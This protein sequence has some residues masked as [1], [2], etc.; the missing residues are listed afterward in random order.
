M[1]LWFSRPCDT[2]GK[3]IGLIF[4]LNLVSIVPCLLWFS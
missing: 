4:D 2:G 3:V 1:A